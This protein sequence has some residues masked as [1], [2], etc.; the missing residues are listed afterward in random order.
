MQIGGS[1]GAGATVVVVAALDAGCVG[2]VKTCGTVAVLVGVLSD[3]ASGGS[4]GWSPSSI[5]GG[6]TLT[7][8]PAGTAGIGGPSPSSQLPLHGL[9]FSLAPAGATRTT[10]RTSAR[11][12]KSH[13]RLTPFMATAGLDCGTAT[14]PRP[15]IHR[16][17]Q[18]PPQLRG[19]QV[20]RQ[21]AHPVGGV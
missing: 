17:R 3:D 8:G 2:T 5:G 4:A 16:R 12:S 7:A 13:L 19:R 21:S 18:L 6:S 20:R 1:F 10:A 15:E 11:P 9:T 14:S